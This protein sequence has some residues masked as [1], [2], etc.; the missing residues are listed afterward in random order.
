M[1][2]LFLACTSNVYF[3]STDSIQFSLSGSDVVELETMIDKSL[4]YR[5]RPTCGLDLSL[6][7]LNLGD[8]DATIYLD[9]DLF[10]DPQEITL[11]PSLAGSQRQEFSDGGSIRCRNKSYFTTLTASAD[12]ELLIE[13]NSRMG[14]TMKEFD[15][16]GPLDMSGADYDLQTETVVLSHSGED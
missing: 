3:S 6:S 15:N 7:A 5:H 4:T 12:A 10:D 11:Q 13:F 2:F 8:G 9:S 1:I 16:F 14:V